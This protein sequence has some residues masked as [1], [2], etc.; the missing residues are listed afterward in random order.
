MAVAMTPVSLNMLVALDAPG[1][2]TSLLK[3]G[4]MATI[5]Y[6]VHTHTHTHKKLV[7]LYQSTAK[8]ISKQILPK[9]LNKN[10][11]P[12]SDSKDNSKDVK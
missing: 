1:V 7:F 9:M 5:S 2:Y 6:Q 12:F 11:Q 3:H 8:K 10:D 4:A